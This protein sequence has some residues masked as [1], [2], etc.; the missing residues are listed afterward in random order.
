MALPHPLNP[1]SFANI[2]VVTASEPR[3]T[4]AGAFWSW[5]RDHVRQR[6][7][8]RA[9]RFFA[10]EAR[11]FV[12]DSMPSRQRQRYGDIDFDW[13]HR[14]DTTEATVSFRNRLLGVFH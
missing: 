14:V 9:T 5:C 4:I 1:R 11:D 6:G 13:E 8:W 2:L 10:Q 7:I 12:R 3:I